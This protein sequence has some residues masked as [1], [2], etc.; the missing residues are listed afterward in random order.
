MNEPDRPKTFD[1]PKCHR[2]ANRLDKLRFMYFCQF[3][4]IHIS[5]KGEIFYVTP[6]G[7]LVSESRLRKEAEASMAHGD[8]INQ[9]RKVL[10][11]ETMAALMAEGKTDKEIALT[12]EL[13]EY[14]V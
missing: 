10:P 8:K 9:A 3:C 1:C 7:R 11:K 12:T 14:V 4:L 5:Y 13:E 2:P 6:N